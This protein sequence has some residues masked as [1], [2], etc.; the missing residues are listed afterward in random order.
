MIDV[1]RTI[2]LHLETIH[3]SVHYLKA[4]EDETFPYLVYEI[5]ITHIEDDLH[6]VTLDIDGW[7]DNEDTTP[8]ELLMNNVQKNLNRKTI[9]NENL[10]MFLTLDRKFSVTDP[11]PQL[12]RRRYI[13]SGRLYERNV[14]NSINITKGG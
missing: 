12:N 8:L 7:D 11:N 3:P 5:E 6:M 13:F 2:H 4:P 10:A 14:S 1:R 9:F